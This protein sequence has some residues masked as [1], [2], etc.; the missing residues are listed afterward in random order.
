MAIE[1]ITH[2]VEWMFEQLKRLLNISKASAS[3][4]TSPMVEKEEIEESRIRV[5]TGEKMLILHLL[6]VLRQIHGL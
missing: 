5:T 4:E 3:N 2:V 6:E 1:H